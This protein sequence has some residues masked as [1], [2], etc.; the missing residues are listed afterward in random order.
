MQ[1]YDAVGADA[2]QSWF[3][4]YMICKI[5]YTVR[6]QYI[7]FAGCD[8][9]D[10]STVCGLALARMFAAWDLY[11]DKEGSCAGSNCSTLISPNG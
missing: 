2:Q 3:I 1:I 9:C 11:D 7:T 8:L 5:Y 6:V 10:L 4:I